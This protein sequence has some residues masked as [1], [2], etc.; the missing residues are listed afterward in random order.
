M[1][2][3][4]G[5]SSS[6]RHSFWST[7]GISFILTDADGAGDLLGLGLLIVEEERH[8]VVTSCDA[9]HHADLRRIPDVEESNT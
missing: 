9:V 1:G 4:L 6:M 2:F 5:P 8:F 3:A 7:A